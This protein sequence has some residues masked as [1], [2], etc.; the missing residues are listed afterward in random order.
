[1]ITILGL[2]SGGYL[3]TKGSVLTAKREWEKL[4]P[5]LQSLTSSEKLTLDE[6]AVVNLKAELSKH[7]A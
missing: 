2:S 7:G 1:M 6:Q 4:L 3:K 5:L